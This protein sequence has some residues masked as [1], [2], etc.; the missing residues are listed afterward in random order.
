MSGENYKN[1]PLPARKFHATDSFICKALRDEAVATNLP[2]VPDNES[3]ERIRLRPEVEIFS[4]FY[5]PTNGCKLYPGCNGAYVIQ[6]T[7]IEVF[8][9]PVEKIS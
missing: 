1:V 7:D 5:P 9:E 4:A 2:Q 8:I 6:G 3:N